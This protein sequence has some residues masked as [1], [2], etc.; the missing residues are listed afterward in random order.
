[1]IY[2]TGTTGAARTTD[3]TIAQAMETIAGYQRCTQEQY[4]AKLQDIEALD[5]ASVLCDRRDF[6]QTIISSSRE[7]TEPLSKEPAK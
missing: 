5:T 2:L 6:Q 3:P 7:E 1:M 4:Y